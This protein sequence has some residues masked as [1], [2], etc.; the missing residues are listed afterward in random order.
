ME[1]YLNRSIHPRWCR[2]LSHEVSGALAFSPYITSDLAESVL[3]QAGFRTCEVHTRFEAEL[4]A[5]GASSLLALKNLLEMGHQLFHV[6]GLHA[7]IIHIPGRF[8]SLGSQNLT[9]A[10]TRNK[11]ASVALDEPEAQAAIDASIRPWIHERTPITSEMISDME[12]LLS[13]VERLYREAQDAAVNVDDEVARRR[14]ETEVL[15]G[16]DLEKNSEEMPPYLQSSSP[17]SQVQTLRRALGTIRQSNHSAWCQVG[18]PDPYSGTVS[19]LADWDSTLTS[20]LVAD[21]R[22]EFVPRMR[23][24]CVLD[25][26]G[27][28]GWVRVVKTRITFVGHGVEDDTP[29]V[30]AGQRCWLHFE[31]DWAA[32]PVQGRNLTIGIQTSGKTSLCTVSVW[33]D[34]QYLTCKAIKPARGKVLATTKHAMTQ[35]I[36]D[37]WDEFASTVLA[38]L[39][40]PFHYQSKLYG[41]GEIE[42]YFGPVGTKYALQVAELKG[43]QHIITA[44]RRN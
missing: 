3:S 24:L 22:V 20:W 28:L 29:A 30:L 2:E 36:E 13:D 33:F 42:A 14:R 25:H 7:K 17:H 26:N 9:R 15:A 31:A 35:W 40:T 6:P 4:F 39:V 37:N 41:R 21:K 16:K 12:E 18:R 34:T 19:L 27:R 44:R 32:R 43:G 1:I 38:R 8:S 11:E 5:S 23:H 10:G